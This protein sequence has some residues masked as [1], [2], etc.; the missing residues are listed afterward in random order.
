[1]RLGKALQLLRVTKG[2]TLRDMAA[3]IGI[4]HT[5]LHRIENNEECEPRAVVKLIAWLIDREASATE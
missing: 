4:T 3:E 5:K 2:Q 1:M